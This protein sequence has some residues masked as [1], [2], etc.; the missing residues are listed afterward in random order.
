MSSTLQETRLST[1]GAT[2]LDRLRAGDRTAFEALMRTHNRRLF[3][4]ARGILRDDAEAEEALQD[5]YLT[6]FQA[7]PGFRGEAS[8]STW[9][10]RIV[11]NAAL[12]RLRRARRDRVVVPYADGM[13]DADGDALNALPD[14]AAI[15]PEDVVMRS[16]LRA[17]LERR[18]DALPLAFRTVF[19]MREIEEM[20]VEETAAALDIPPGTVRTRLFRA[21][22]LLRTALAQEIDAITPETYAFAGARCDRIV[23]RVLFRLATSHP[24]ES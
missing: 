19:I 8:L 3:R 15:P 4:V 7:L 17:L 24:Q 22:A 23:Q 6:A 1:D 13:E 12:G 5:A 9:L 21:R 20:T 10:V 14:P 11:V 18:I 16:E 2:A